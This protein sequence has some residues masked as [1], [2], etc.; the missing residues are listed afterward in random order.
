[1]PGYV[2]RAAVDQDGRVNDHPAAPADPTDPTDPTALRPVLWSARCA[3]GALA[4]AGLGW[5]ARAVWQI[6]L[7]VAGQPASGPPDQGGGQHRTLTSL[8][9]A[10]HVVSALSDATTAVCALMFLSW[11]WRVRDNARALSG[12]RPRYVWFWM[13]LGWILPVA[14][15]WIPR[16]LVVDVYR[17]SAPGEPLPRSVNWWWG[18]WLI[19]V[20]TGV[21]FIY[22]DDTDEVIARAYT[23]IAWLLAS[24][25]VIVGAAVAGIFVVRAITAVQRDRVE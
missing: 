17:A 10:Y 13:Y 3:V 15:L 16:G 8:E 22:A 11:L 25:A 21:S 12:E 24:D 4:L 1:V 23:D 14:N 5:L 18:L 2:R 20:L 6:R 19:G 7:A 9:D